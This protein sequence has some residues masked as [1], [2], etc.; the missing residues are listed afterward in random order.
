MKNSNDIIGN[1]TPYL[2]ACSAVSKPT[3]PPHTPVSTYMLNIIIII[4]IIVIII[5]IITMI[6][7]FCVQSHDSNCNQQKHVAEFCI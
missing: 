2:P 3:V 4:I 7:Y 6:K 1:R 5:I